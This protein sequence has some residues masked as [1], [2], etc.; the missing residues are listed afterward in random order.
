MA[1]LQGKRFPMRRA[2]VVVVSAIVLAVAFCLSACSSSS[3]EATGPIKLEIRDSVAD[4]Y[5]A[6]NG[7]ARLEM[8]GAIT[9]KSEMKT[10]Q[11]SDMPQLTMDGEVVE[12]TYDPIDMEKADKVEPGK[13]IAYKISFEFDPSKDHE[14]K[15]KS[16]DDTVVDGLDEYASIKEALRNFKGK[17]QVTMEDLAEIEREA[18]ARYQKFLEEEANK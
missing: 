8:Q 6:Q 13:S 2:F 1:F 3:N 15:F 5:P 12:A 7:M 18:E 11:I 16:A 9:N 4:V 17:P 10:A 14:W